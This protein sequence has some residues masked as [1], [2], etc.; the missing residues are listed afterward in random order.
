[1]SAVVEQEIGDGAARLTARGAVTRARILRAA[2]DL[3]YVRGIGLT[4]LDDVRAASG[5]SKSQLYRYFPDKEALV[6]EVIALQAAALL[7]RERERLER[8]NS[9]RGLERWRDALVQSTALRD[10]AYG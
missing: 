1:M 5:T 6:R 4:T 3:M 2:A 9:V 7:E 8:L 10:G